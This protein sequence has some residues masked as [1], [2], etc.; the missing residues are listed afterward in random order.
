MHPPVFDALL[1]A[2]ADIYRAE[3]RDA[4]ERTAHALT[5]TPAPEAFERQ[6]PCALDALM[7]DLLATSD[8]PAAQAILAAQDLIP[9]GTNPVAD[10]MSDDAAAICA[11]TTL[12]GPDGPI[13]APD[14]RLGLFY[15][16]PNS[17][18]ALHNHDA[19][20]TYVILAGEA[21]W[22]AGEDRR[23]RRPGDM[24]HHPSLMPHA[25][26]TGPEG[27]LA[28]W[29]WSGDVNTHSYAFLPDPE[30]QVA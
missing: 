21:F 19:D 1:T 14:L 30:A 27:V 9:W 16:R 24:I 3:G 17:Y 25:F 8:H 18:Y 4:A 22:T 7:R 10:R 15:Q 20:E 2:L 13:P 23:T 28:L 12:M 29:R 11:V 5:T 26:R 6:T